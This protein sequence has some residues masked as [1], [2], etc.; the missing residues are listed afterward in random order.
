MPARH[1]CAPNAPRHMASGRMPPTACI[2]LSLRSLRQGTRVLRRQLR[3]AL[4]CSTITFLLACLVSSSLSQA[5]GPQ[6][7]PST[8]F[9]EMKWRLIGPFRG[10]RSL[11]A[12]GIP[13]QPAVYYFGAVGG[14]V[15][16]STDAGMT[17]DPIFDNQPIASIGALAVAPSAPN[18]IYVGSGEADM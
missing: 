3:L 7:V 2:I 4:S 9:S 8:P 15:W 12:V 18:V 13:G 11:T 17:W 1:A 10:G 16:K 6:P 14:G 5:G